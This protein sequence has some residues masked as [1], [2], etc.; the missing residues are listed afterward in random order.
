MKLGASGETL[1]SAVLPPRR[2]VPLVVCPTQ[3]RRVRTREQSHAPGRFTE[4]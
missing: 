3:R 2:S 4:E 1:Y